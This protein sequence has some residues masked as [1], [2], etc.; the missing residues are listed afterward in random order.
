M[1]YSTKFITILS[2]SV[3]GTLAQASVPLAPGA[4]PVAL[5]GSTASTIPRLGG[6]VAHDNLIP[7]QIMSATGALLYKGVLQDRVIRSSQT[8]TLHFYSRIRDTTPGLNGIVASV[9]RLNFA[10][11]PMVLVDWRPDGLGTVAPIVASRSAMPGVQIGYNFVGPI[12]P[13]LFSGQESRFFYAE[14]RVKN[15]AITGRTIIRLR[16][17]Q[18]VVLQTATPLTP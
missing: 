17:G 16:T 6:T 2:I 11:T 18:S 10:P 4:G 15:F 12:Q 13:G 1:K 3:L 7:F 14:T 5:P 8:Q 9:A